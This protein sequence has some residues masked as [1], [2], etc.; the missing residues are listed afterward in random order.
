M[1]LPSFIPPT[2]RAGLQV[3]MTFYII[4]RRHVN[5]C[6]HNRPPFFEGTWAGPLTGSPAGFC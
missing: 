2:Q 6:N 1:T 5:M 3:R 4:L